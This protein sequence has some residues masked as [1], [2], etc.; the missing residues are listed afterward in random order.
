MTKWI[1]VTLVG[2]FLTGLQ[3]ENLT[4]E[5]ELMM[6][7]MMMNAMGGEE[8]IV[9]I[10]KKEIL[11]SKES[12]AFAKECFGSADTLK[13]ANVCI[14]KGN[15]RFKETEKPLE[16][17]TKEDKDTMLKEI[18]SFEKVVPCIENAKSIKAIEQC[19]PEDMK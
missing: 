17:W 10:M 15:E 9:E 2:L 7:Q 11:G 8:K 1:K 5:Q 6:Q 19:M 12:I 4:A 18:H 14:A 16:S 3:A 13:E